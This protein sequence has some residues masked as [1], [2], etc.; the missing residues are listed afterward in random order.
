MYNNPRKSLRILPESSNISHK[1][2]R[3]ESILIF[4]S[5]D[6]LHGTISLEIFGFVEFTEP[7]NHWMI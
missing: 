6:G 2:V 7:C 3:H 4:I 5:F 1:S